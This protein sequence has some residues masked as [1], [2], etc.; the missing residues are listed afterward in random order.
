[1][2]ES[3]WEL[4]LSVSP[5]NARM[6][7]ARKDAGLSQADLAMLVGVP[8]QTISAVETLRRM[9]ELELAQ[10]IADAL[11]ESVERLFPVWTARLHDRF[12]RSIAVPITDADVLPEWA[13]RR[14]LGDTLRDMLKSL[15]PRES[16]VLSLRFGLDGQ[17][18]ST[19]EEVAAAMGRVTRERIRQIEANAL[20]KLRHSS[21]ADRLRDF[22]PLNGYADLVQHE[23]EEQKRQEQEKA[24]CDNLLRGG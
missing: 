20:R 2:E 12:A 4:G 17:G 5:Y 16:R 23:R 15:K 14:E 1:M 10:E 22:L 13:G 11:S 8:T 19:Y 18:S 7:A 6:R 9:P 21:R 24:K 3:T